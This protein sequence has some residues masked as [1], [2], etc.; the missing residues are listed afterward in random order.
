MK[1]KTF[2]NKLS[3]ALFVSLTWLW[4]S[5]QKVI[6]KEFILSTGAQV[7]LVFPWVDHVNFQGVDDEIPLKII[8]TAEGEYQNQIF[9]SQASFCSL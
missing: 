2:R 6:E 9:L 7:E 3:L 1:L 8:Y 4:L 5:A